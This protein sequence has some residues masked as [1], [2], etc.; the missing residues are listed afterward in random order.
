M[1]RK[2]GR[3]IRVNRMLESVF[4]KYSSECPRISDKIMSYITLN[5]FVLSEF[6]P[7]IPQKVITTAH[8]RKLTG[9]DVFLKF[10]TTH[11]SYL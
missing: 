11:I 8:R 3:G 4:L 1:P 2:G 9:V 7:S 10:L 5:R 6:E